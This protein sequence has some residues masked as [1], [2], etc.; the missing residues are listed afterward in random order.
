M[1]DISGQIHQARYRLSRLEWQHAIW[2][3][4]ERGG[5]WQKWRAEALSI[6][7]PQLREA[8]LEAAQPSLF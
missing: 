6:L 4:E 7:E 2:I 1:P 5:D 8:R 3:A